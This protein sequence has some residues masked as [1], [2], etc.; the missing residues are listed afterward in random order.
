MRIGGLTLVSGPI[1]DLENSALLP[2]QSAA[3]YNP[4]RLHLLYLAGDDHSFGPYFA[5]IITV[6]QY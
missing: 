2:G 1:N 5:P 4:D 6:C 3:F